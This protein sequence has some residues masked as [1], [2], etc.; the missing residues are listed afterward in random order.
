MG[1]GAEVTPSTERREFS[2]SSGVYGLSQTEQAVILAFLS[3][4]Y[5]EC[6]LQISSTCFTRDF[7]GIAE[8]QASPRPTE[9]EPEFYQDPWMHILFLIHSTNMEEPA[10]AKP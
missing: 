10:C 4:C 9:L 1:G 5:A 3:T 8:S 2:P 7:V 6:G